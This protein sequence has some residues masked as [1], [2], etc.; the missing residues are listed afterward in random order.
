MRK[1]LFA[2]I[3][4]LL[5]IIA[6]SASAKSVGLFTATTGSVEVQ[7]I[8]EDEARPARAGDHLNETDI[9]RT[10][11]SATAE[12][13]FHDGN[14]VL[15]APKTYMKIA[16]Y[17]IKGPESSEIIELLYGKL[18]NIVETVFGKD[19]KTKMGRYEVHTP[20]AICGVRG[21]DFFVSH[22][23]GISHAVFAK[24]NGYAFSRN[25]PDE[26]VTI[27]AGQTMVAKS[28]NKAP[29]VGRAKAG[30]IEKLKREMPR[31]ARQDKAKNRVKESK[32]ESK[33]I[34]KPSKDTAI[35]DKDKGT[36]GKSGDKG[37][38]KTD[39][40]AGSVSSGKSGESSGGSGGSSG[41]ASGSSGSSG[42]G[43]SGGSGGSSGGSGNSGGGSSG[44]GASGGS[45][46][47]SGGGNSGGGGKK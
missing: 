46:G 34:G 6:A 3:I 39:S 14:I 41:G 40:D 36:P 27:T 18:R 31:H 22:E 16:E 9:V 1:T 7:G 2:A 10:D 35:G 12:I 30:D 17:K 13:T 43:A 29:S 20:T 26:V 47:N 45:G 33:T 19:F 38:A 25:V 21:T 37:S 15:L 28:A 24:G 4:V 11:D 42:G 23:R 5:L 8:L 32:K 44:G